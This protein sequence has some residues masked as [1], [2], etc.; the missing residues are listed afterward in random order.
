MLELGNGERGQRSAVTLADAAVD[1]R[2]S[3]LGRQIEQPQRVADGD[4]ALADLAGDRLVRQSEPIDELAVGEGG[5]DRVQI[6]SLEVLDE[7]ELERVRAVADVADDRR[8]GA[9]ARQPCGP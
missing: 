3:R 2:L 9:Q 1:D 5:V 8:N 6:L 7:R 4:P